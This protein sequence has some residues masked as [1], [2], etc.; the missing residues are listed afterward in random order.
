MR[1]MTITLMNSIVSFKI[2]TV[3]QIQRNIDKHSMFVTGRE[4]GVEIA[5][6]LNVSIIALLL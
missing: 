5:L 6:K 3:E 1:Q 2:M 4:G